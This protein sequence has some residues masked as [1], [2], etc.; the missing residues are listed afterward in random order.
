VPLQVNTKVVKV[1]SRIYEITP[2]TNE[3]ALIYIGSSSCPY[4]RSTV[5]DSTLSTVSNTLL[6]FTNSKK[7]NLTKIGLSGDENLASGLEHLMSLETSF[8]ENFPNV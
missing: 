1:D 4:C 7:V 5:L 8:K 6:D 2:S 3:I